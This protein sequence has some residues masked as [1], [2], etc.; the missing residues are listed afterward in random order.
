MKISPIIL[1]LR[2]WCPSFEKR[3]GGTADLPT[4]EESTHLILPCAFVLAPRDE[5]AELLVANRYIQDI[6]VTFDIVL[7]A[8][9][10]A[11]E[12]GLDAYDKVDDLKLE[13]IRALAGC[14][15]KDCNEW[16]HYE[17]GQVEALNAAY[18]SYRMSFSCQYRI[19]DD[20]TMHGIEIAGLPD[21]LRL[22]TD[23]KGTDADPDGKKPIATLDINFKED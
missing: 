4:S 10:S 23:F 1:H 19:T 18:L 16:L 13:I 7:Y 14:K 22:H 17:G 5:S 15:P 8:S 3:I 9:A 2:T 12:R 11:D 6:P 21:F 20:M